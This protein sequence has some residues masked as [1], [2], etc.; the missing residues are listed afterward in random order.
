VASNIHLPSFDSI[1][2]VLSGWVDRQSLEISNKLLTLP[3]VTLHLP[4]VKGLVAR[5]VEKM[6]AAAETWFGTMSK[7]AEKTGEA[8]SK[9]D[10]L[11]V[12]KG[13]KRFDRYRAIENQ[14]GLY[15]TNALQ[16]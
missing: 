16:G 13:E 6:E 4:E 10:T 12:P 9:I 7:S 3:S 1:T 11:E 2:G 8:L 5:D 15:N 14:A